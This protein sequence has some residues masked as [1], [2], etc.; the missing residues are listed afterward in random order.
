MSQSFDFTSYNNIKRLSEDELVALWE[1]YNEKDIP[2]NLTDIEVKTV[3]NIEELITI[4]FEC[5]AGPIAQLFGLTATG[6]NKD[7]IIDLCKTS[8]RI[9]S[10]GYVF[11]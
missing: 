10:V 9:A 4:L 1:E 3:E 8:I 5:L 2:K 11:M 6:D 7:T